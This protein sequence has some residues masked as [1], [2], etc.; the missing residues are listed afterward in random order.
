MWQ[1][2]AIIAGFGLVAGVFVGLLVSGNLLVKS[3]TADAET[4]VIEDTVIETEATEETKTEETK[5]TETTKNTT[6]PTTT[7]TTPAPDSNPPI[8]DSDLGCGLSEVEKYN[9]EK[10]IKD[11]DRNYYGDPSDTYYTGGTPLFNEMTGQTTE[12]CQYI[13]NNHP[14]RP[15]NS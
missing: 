12:R 13:L 8:A 6:P 11:T 3:K 7:T 15:W 5:S 10:W 9:I 4:A 14:T 1:R 2:V